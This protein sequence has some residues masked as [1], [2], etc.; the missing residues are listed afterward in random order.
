MWLV[1]IEIVPTTDAKLTWKKGYWLYHGARKTVGM[2][3]QKPAVRETVHLEKKGWHLI[4]VPARYSWADIGVKH[5]DSQTTKVAEQ[6]DGPEAPHWMSRFLWEYSPAL[7]STYT[8]YDA[9]KSNYTM[10]EWK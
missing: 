5:G 6:A 4:V 10:D 9:S 2:A 1:D 3:A 7:G 8:A